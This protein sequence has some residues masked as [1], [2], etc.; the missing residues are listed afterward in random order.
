[1]YLRLMRNPE[2]E[3]RKESFSIDWYSDFWKT[4]KRLPNMPTREEFKEKSISVGDLA[5]RLWEVVEIQAIHIEELNQRIKCLEQS[6]MPW[7]DK[8]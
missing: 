3:F 4:N 1:M 2:K 7:S 8:P 5:Q 6:R